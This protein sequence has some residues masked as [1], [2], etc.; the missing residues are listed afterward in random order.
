[1]D[2]PDTSSRGS[3]NKLMKQINLAYFH[4]YKKKYGYSGHFWQDRY[5]SLLISKDE[6]L[7]AC[8]RYIELN[9]VKAHIVKD[10]KDYKWSSYNVYAY[11]IKDNITDINP[12]YKECGNTEE[13]KCANYKKGMKEEIEKANLNFN[14]KFMG[15]QKFI[16]AMEGKFKT[17]NLRLK[18]GRPRI[19]KK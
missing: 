9:P 17:K 2:P 19:I 14:A 15:T 8:G 1:M 4:Y 13:E 5:K 16:K 7:I 12:I 10:P 6:Y 18:R 3:I 11:G